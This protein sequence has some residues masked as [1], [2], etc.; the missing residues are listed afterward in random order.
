MADYTV[1]PVEKTSI[2]RF[3][4]IRS[5][6]TVPTIAAGT[7]FIDYD[8]PAAVADRASSS[9]QLLYSQL[10]SIRANNS[11]DGAAQ[12]QAMQQAIDAFKQT[13]RFVADTAALTQ[14]ADFYRI[15][16]G[17]YLRAQVEL[18]EAVRVEPLVKSIVCILCL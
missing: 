4:H 13:A 9:P 7:H 16:W 8:I 15:D 1:V 11:L 18:V 2:M 17:R 10:A 5:A 6:K 14:V 3:V 12:R